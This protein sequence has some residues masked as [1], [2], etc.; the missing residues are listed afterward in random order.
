MRRLSALLAA[1][2]LA[3]RCAAVEV[4]VPAVPDAIALPA[5][6]VPAVQPQAAALPGSL[7]ALP[8]LPAQITALTAAVGVSQAGRTAAPAASQ[9][10]QAAAG[11]PAASAA[12]DGA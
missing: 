7:Q 6:N 1:L 8:A 4:G 12:F 11:E 2:F 3:G 5:A 10:A 9:Q